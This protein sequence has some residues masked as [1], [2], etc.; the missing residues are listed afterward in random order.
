MNSIRTVYSVSVW[1]DD[2]LRHSSDN[3][4]IGLILCQ[5]KKRIVAEYALR[6]LDKAIGVSEYELSRHLPEA[7]KGSLPEIEELEAELA[8][9]DED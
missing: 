6:G 2:Q 8:S 3:P 4:T 7:V 9:V 1:R 5:D